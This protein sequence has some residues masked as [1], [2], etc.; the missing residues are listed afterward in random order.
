MDE[1]NTVF[2]G[3]LLVCLHELLLGFG[4]NI[5]EQASISGDNRHHRLNYLLRITPKIL[6]PKEF[7]IFLDVR[8]LDEVSAVILP[9][10]GG[11]AHRLVETSQESPP[12]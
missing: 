10:K 11:L 4:H 12:D 1:S 5:A 2:P 6:I 9:L 7:K 3:F 8:S